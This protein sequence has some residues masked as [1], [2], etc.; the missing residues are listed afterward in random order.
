MIQ[1]Q[2]I[3]MSVFMT[4][5]RGLLRAAACARAHALYAV[6]KR[7]PGHTVKFLMCRLP[8]DALAKMAIKKLKHRLV[9][10]AQCQESVRVIL[11]WMLVE[12]LA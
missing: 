11:T 8:S 12:C 6:R 2:Q 4:P 9:L 7:W 3:W 1:L 10:S 5:A